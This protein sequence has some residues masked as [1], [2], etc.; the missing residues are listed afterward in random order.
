MIWS[1]SVVFQKSILAAK[2]FF[3]LTEEILLGTSIWKNIESRICFEHLSNLG[4]WLGVANTY[5][6]ATPG[7]PLPDPGLHVKA[8]GSSCPGLLLRL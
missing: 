8:T 7:G 6:V 4:W 3:F 1:I 5:K 2:C